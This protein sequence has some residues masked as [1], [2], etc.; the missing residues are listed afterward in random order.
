M[1]E[2]IQRIK[3][4][5]CPSFPSAVLILV[6]KAVNQEQGYYINK[7]IYQI[8]FKSTQLNILNSYNTLK[9]PVIKHLNII[10][11]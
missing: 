6:S 7:N 1:N 10:L 11:V 5:L 4:I 2:K 3:A 8:K 9:I